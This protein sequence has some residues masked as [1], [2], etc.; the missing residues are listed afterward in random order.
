MRVFITYEVR[1]RDSVYPC[2]MFRHTDGR[3]RAMSRT[4]GGDRLHH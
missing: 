3:V 1:S 2:S 4:V